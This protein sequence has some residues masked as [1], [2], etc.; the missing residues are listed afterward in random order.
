MDRRR[1][2]SRL[3]VLGAALCALGADGASPRPDA[4][5]IIVHPDNPAREV[6]R[7]F[8]RD[9]YLRKVV[10]WGDGETIR[11]LDL[12][13]RFP[14]RERF[15][16]DVIG[17]TLAQLRRYWAQ[18]IFSGKAVPAPEVDSEAA[19]IRYVLRHRGAVGYLPAGADPGGARVV[20]LK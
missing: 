2:I 15:A 19:A 11:P 17:K 16:R 1:L 3:L 4:F 5:Q 13:R 7:G 14:Q 8:L 18:Q 10:T 9:A 6:S 20:R 12:T